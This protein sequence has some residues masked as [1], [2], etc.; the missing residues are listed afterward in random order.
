M[1]TCCRCW[2]T[3]A[4]LN[5]RCLQQ[6]PHPSKNMPLLLPSKPN[7]FS[8]QKWPIRPIQGNIHNELRPL[9]FVATMAPQMRLATCSKLLISAPIS[10]LKNSPTEQPAFIVA[11][12]LRCG[13]LQMSRK[14]WKHQKTTKKNYRKEIGPCKPLRAAMASIN[15]MCLRTMS[16]SSPIFHHV[17]TLPGIHHNESFQ[18]V[19]SPGLQMTRLTSLAHSNDF[20]ESLAHT[21]HTQQSITPLTSKNCSSR[22]IFRPQ[23]ENLEILDL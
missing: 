22:S 17:C 16:W 8:E 7:V 2:K 19:Y 1:V 15:A 3:A 18:I 11:F 9:F 23:M 21:Q 20:Q 14:I 5:Q 6:H 4:H 12:E 13:S 10:P